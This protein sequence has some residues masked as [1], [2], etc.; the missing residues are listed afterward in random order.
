MKL[1]NREKKKVQLNITSL[2]DV[3][4]LLL[5][6]FMLTTRF[7]EQPGMKLELPQSETSENIIA[8]NLEL[9]VI[10][11]TEIRLNGEVIEM[12]DLRNKFETILLQLEEKTL[13][14][15]ADKTVSHG[16]IVEIMDIARLSGMEKI[17]IATS[18]K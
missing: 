6:F 9:V 11:D 17:V 18:V 12:E 1:F 5:I 10:S 13:I 2:I 16:S 14:L 4:L 7:I 8:Q 3:V 15:K